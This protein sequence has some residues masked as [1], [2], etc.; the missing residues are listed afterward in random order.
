MAYLTYMSYVVD[1][2][3]INWLVDGSILL[4]DLPS[5][6]QFLAT[7]VQIDEVNKTRDEERRACLFLKFAEVSPQIVPTESFVFDVSRWDHGKWSDGVLFEKLKSSLDTLNNSKAN[8]AKDALIGEVA[9]VNG[10][11]LLT[12]DTDLAQIVQAHGG[13]VQLFKKAK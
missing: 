3:I 1:T 9:V 6:G 5:N 2:N 7:H 13:K 4:E 10:Y 11:T 8:N 12:A